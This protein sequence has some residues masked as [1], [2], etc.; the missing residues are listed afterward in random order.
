[1]L[2][3]VAG[4]AGPAPPSP[5]EIAQHARALQPRDARLAQLYAQS[6]RACHAEPRS[7][8]PLAGDRAAW[9]P[10]LAKGRAALLASVVNGFNGMPAGGQCFECTGAD[11]ERLIGFMSGAEQP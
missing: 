1:M 5:Q 10:R 9:A 7:T 3:L 8:A 6:C 4:C 2:A 11:F